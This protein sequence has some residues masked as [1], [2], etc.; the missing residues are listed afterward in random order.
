[1][2][3]ASSC[4]DRVW[5]DSAAMQ[6]E[7]IATGAMARGAIALDEV[8]LDR[9]PSDMEKHTYPW[10]ARRYR[11]CRKRDFAART[12]CAQILIQWDGAVQA[13]N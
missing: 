13:T 3:N 2:A 5:S 12:A 9:K 10:C 7:W 4:A 6:R 8:N 11:K 1:M